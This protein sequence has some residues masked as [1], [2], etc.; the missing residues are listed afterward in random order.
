[1]LVPVTIQQEIARQAP[2]LIAY[3]PSQLAPGWRYS[4]WTT[5]GTM[6]VIVF[7]NSAGKT[8]D[9]VVGRS[10]GT[11][12]LA[13]QKTFQT[14]GVKTYWNH[15]AAQ[16]QAWRCVAGVTLTAV[17]SLPPNRFADVG[18]ARLAASGRRLRG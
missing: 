3:V 8:V 12:G 6:L 18:L 1:V 14:A 7:R 5:T 15:S 10:F 17:T 11:C 16:Q 9:F 13:A 4:S 2:P